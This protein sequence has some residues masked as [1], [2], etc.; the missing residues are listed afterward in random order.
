NPVVRGRKAGPE[1]PR[2]PL[3]FRRARL[4]LLACPERAEGESNGCRNSFQKAAALDSEV[5]LSAQA[6]PSRRSSPSAAHYSTFL[7]AVLVFSSLP[8][9][10]QVLS[11]DHRCFVHTTLFRRAFTLAVTL[12]N[13]RRSLAMW[14]WVKIPASG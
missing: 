2:R 1:E 4:R 6:N 9:E 12:M 7:P 3:S 14:N 10:Y 5:A 11:T 13:P 8:T